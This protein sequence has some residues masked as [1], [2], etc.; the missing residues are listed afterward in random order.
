MPNN[1]PD[2]QGSDT[3]AAD[4]STTDGYT[5][6]LSQEEHVPHLPMD[7]W[8]KIRLQFR[9]RQFRFYID[10]MLVGTRT[11]DAPMTRLYWWTLHQFSQRGEV[12]YIRITDVNGRYLYNEEFEDAQQLAVTDRS[13]KCGGCELDYTK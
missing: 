7:V 13:L 11:L 10:S 9:G 4:S 3:T 8:R 12:D 5:I 1:E 6:V 2:V